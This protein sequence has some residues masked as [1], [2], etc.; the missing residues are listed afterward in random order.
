MI[1][2]KPT[3]HPRDI[4][5]SV[6]LLREAASSGYVPAMHELGLLLVNHPEVN[7]SKDEALSLLNQAADAGTW[8]S[9]VVLG[10][11]ARDG[12]L[13]PKDDQMA[14]LHFQIAVLQGDSTT[15]NF[16][17]TDLKTVGNRI[18]AN[19][20]SRIEKE[21][22]AWTEKHKLA[23]AVIYKNGEHM[24]QFPAFAL[25]ATAPHVHAAPLIPSNPY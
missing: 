18:G 1:L 10:I 9:S 22:K 24:S 21:A 13:V 7:Q 15:E 3:D 8:R 19:E 11:L 2:S 5:R 14:Y 6:A 17:R 12:K 16:L 20:R 23:L 25:A 4:Q